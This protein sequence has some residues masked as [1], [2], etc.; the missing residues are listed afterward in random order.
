MELR[1]PREILIGFSLY[2]RMYEWTAVAFGADDSRS[3]P[4]WFRGSCLREVSGRRCIESLP[5]GANRSFPRR[6][7]KRMIFAYL[8]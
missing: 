6:R 5:I 4:L 2:R 7:W 1:E 3:G 8:I